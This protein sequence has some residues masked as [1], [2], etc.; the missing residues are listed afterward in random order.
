MKK[1]GTLFGS[2][3]GSETDCKTFLDNQFEEHSKILEKNS[4]I[5]KTSPKNVYSCYTNGMQEK[6]SF[7]AK[8]IPRKHAG[9]CEKILQENLIPNLN[10]K[11]NI[12]HQ[13]KDIAPLLLKMGG[14]NIKLPFD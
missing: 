8:I 4:K 7:L 2:V 14:I 6:L 10:I 9:L 11:D 1:G 3:I 12:S 13:L 5:A